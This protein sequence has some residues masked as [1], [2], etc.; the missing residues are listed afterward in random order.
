[1]SVLSQRHRAVLVGTIAVAAVGTVFNPLGAR[2]VP[3]QPYRPV[4]QDQIQ[5]V[6]HAG[7]QI[8]PGPQ[9]VQDSADLPAMASGPF[10]PAVHLSTPIP[11]PSPTPKPT[12]RPTSRPAP[13]APAWTP[14]PVATP[15]IVVQHIAVVRAT[16]R[17]TV[18]VQP[19]AYVTATGTVAQ[20][21]QYA[22]S[23]LGS[24]QYQCLYSLFERESTWRTFA[25]NPYTGAYGI[26]QALPGSKMATAG[27]DWATNPVTQV[28]WGISY[29]DGTYGSACGAWNHELSH[30]WY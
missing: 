28:K 15:R 12:P 21:Q 5:P 16:P 29:V 14:R 26:P 9:I 3:P 18:R 11:S 1:M 20:A 13:A 22:L 27:A 10:D 17:P 6:A 23:R 19:L 24:V 8:V 25:R 2:A 4:P 30:G 7:P